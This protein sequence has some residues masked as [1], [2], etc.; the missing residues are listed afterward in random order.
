MLF[1]HGY[2]PQ[3]Q[4]S[5][6]MQPDFRKT[7]YFDHIAMATVS[8]RFLNKGKQMKVVFHFIDYYNY[9]PIGDC[10]FLLNKVE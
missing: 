9:T 8:G 10:E 3:Q 7:P 4:D 1:R 6:Y 5:F 2:Y